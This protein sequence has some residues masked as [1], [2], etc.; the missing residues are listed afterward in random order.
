M[1]WGRLLTKAC[2]SALLGALAAGCSAPSVGQFV[3]QRLPDEPTFSPVAELLVV[4]CGSLDCHGK[5]GRNLR[6]F[7]SA[8][9]RLSPSE[10]P[11]VPLCDTAAEVSQDYDSLVG[12][13]PELLGG[14]VA[15][16]D[17]SALTLVRKARG[18]E[19]HKG[20]T[21]WAAGD[22][23]DTCLVGWLQGDLKPAACARGVASVLPGSTSNA[24]LTCLAA[25]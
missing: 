7:G 10:S 16:G 20:G 1:T 23:S 4:R 8:G 9:L 2:T 15:G 19:A 5:I 25:P 3:P 18:A 13:E 6:L 17:P 14:V 21:I 11:F 22:D 12:L 24:L